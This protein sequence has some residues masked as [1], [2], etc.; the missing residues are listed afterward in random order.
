MT[1]RLN[2][3]E[4]LQSH[5]WRTACTLASRHLQQFKV[6]PLPP[7]PIVRTDTP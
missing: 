3:I 5:C 7:Q 6:Q 4:W 1:T 2:C